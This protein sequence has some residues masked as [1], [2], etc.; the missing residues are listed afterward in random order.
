VRALTPAERARRA[1]VLGIVLPGPSAPPPPAPAPRPDGRVRAPIAG[2]LTAPATL[3][4]KLGLR[5]AEP[6]PPEPKPKPFAPPVGPSKQERKRALQRQRYLRA[7]RLLASRWPAVFTAARPLA[8]GIDKQVRAVLSE[9]ELSAAELRT[10]FR[11]WIHRGAY[12]AAL[13]RGD[14]RV[15]LDGSDAGP[16][17]DQPPEEVPGPG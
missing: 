2:K 17:F 7:H 13:E 5:V 11:I 4:A 12:R 8:I 16:A 14:R 1:A 9:E 10:F 6:P 3:R 15:N